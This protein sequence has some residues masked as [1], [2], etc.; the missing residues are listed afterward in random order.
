M[1]EFAPPSTPHP[2]PQQPLVM[3][4]DDDFQIQ[5]LLQ[6][7]LEREGYKVI[8]AGNGED[9]LMLFQQMR[10]D[11]VLLDIMMPGLDGIET[12]RRLRQFP[13]A[14][15]IPILML[16]ALADEAAVENAFAA[17][18]TDFLIKP[19]HFTVLRHRV[20]RLVK[21]RQAEIQLHNTEARMHSIV[22]HALDAIIN[23]TWEGTVEF[24]NPAAERM[25]G[26]SGSE[27]RGVAIQ[28]LLDIE[29]PKLLIHFGIPLESQGIRQDGSTFP[30]EI[31]M[32]RF[33]TDH[34]DKFTVIV[35]DITERKQAEVALRTSH[36]IV[37]KTID[38]L[39][40][41]IAI[42][43][44]KGTILSVNAAWRDFADS[45]QMVGNYG[46][47]VN[48]LAVC[49]SACGPNADE[50]SS[51]ATGIRNVLTG[52]Q[53][54]FVLE[55]PCHSPTR[56]RWYSLL[57]TRITDVSPAIGTRLVVMHQDT[58]LRR[59][60]EDALRQTYR[61]S[62]ER[63]RQA[64]IEWVATVDAISDMILLVDQSGHIR[65]CNS[66]VVRLLDLPYTRLIGRL[67]DEIFFCQTIGDL[68]F[69]GAWPPSESTQV[70]RE[71]QLTGFAGQWFEVRSYW[72]SPER[73]IGAG[74]VHIIEDITARKRAEMEMRLLLTAIEQ[75]A[76]AIMIFN[77]QGIVEYVNPAF[78]A[79]TGF[80][81]SEIINQQFQTQ[82]FK[83]TDEKT[84][85]KIIRSV[86]K[87]RWWQGDY[88]ALTKTGQ[89]CVVEATISPIRSG[90]GEVINY[91]A[92]GRDVT[93]KRRLES[94]A[95]AVNMM[96]NVGYIFSGIRH[97]MGNPINSVK[98]ALTFLKINNG[99]CQ[100]ETVSKYV[101]RA[102]SEVSRVEYLL[103][104]L[105]TFSMHENP[106]L[107]RVDLTLF[108]QK[109]FALVSDDFGR[110][111]I[112]LERYFAPGLPFVKIDQRALHQVLMNLFSNSAD[113][114]EGSEDPKI[115]I[116]A[117][118][119]DKRV[120]IE[121]E[122]NGVGMIEEQVLNLFKPFHTSKP[123]G[124][125]LGLVITKRM[126]TRMNGTITVT[127]RPSV[128][129][130]VGLSF[131]PA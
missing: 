32:S 54:E 91:V 119:K 3:V 36:Q 111:G 9:A 115:K 67:I 117:F 127:S 19:I 46:I 103:R 105:R 131:S 108:I 107:E 68:D 101:D 102:L 40:A 58:T 39:K 5:R 59:L 12:C 1:I 84:L 60:T 25:F 8:L 89:L 95:E 43:D 26:L 123:H 47:G 51:V 82:F 38:A 80:T 4:V 81:E 34:Y 126:V 17:E 6:I 129:T 116:S 112:L 73:E 45:N 35:R 27:T 24:L 93:E 64:E 28:K 78:E 79:I 72:I 14:E 7:T 48:Y 114:L 94:I 130:T 120:W 125:G 92:V 18:A 69:C 16:T 122:D 104:T 106:Q 29:D 76:E 96:D 121:I 74:W 66:A 53:R 44:D 13:G 22:F 10:P 41:H 71:V 11:L 2:L 83:P 88:Q 124:T 21:A 52:K 55:Y 30:A 90:Q 42:L 37:Q 62:Q 65:R 33:Q 57:V 50:A 87:G 97:E 56:Q 109:F 77:A 98:T 85:L 31:S 70:I 23:F 15:K 99:Q 128:G 75:A 110:R 49:D 100:P 86:M 63:I 61:Q 20:R 113:A 118:V